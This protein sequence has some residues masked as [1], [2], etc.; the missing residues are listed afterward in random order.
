MLL[1]VTFTI[2][3]IR[4]IKM[5]LVNKS[6]NPLINSFFAVIVSTVK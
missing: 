3:T 1:N 4:I 5:K 6:V 2:L